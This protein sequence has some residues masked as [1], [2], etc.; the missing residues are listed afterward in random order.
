MYRLTPFL[1]RKLMTIKGFKR[2]PGQGGHK[3]SEI[4]HADIPRS[5]FKRNQGIKTAFDGGYLVPIYVDEALPGDTFSVR[6]SSVAR[7]ATPIV[8]FMD[9]LTMEFFFFSV[10]NRLLW[11]NWK[12]FMGEQDDPV[13]S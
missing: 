13:R 12:K 7:L 8:P 4:P 6:L 10:P 1:E 2:T 5:V 11:T 9:N 3:F